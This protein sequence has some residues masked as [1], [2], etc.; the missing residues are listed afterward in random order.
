MLQKKAS[1]ENIQ[2]GKVNFNSEN[3][4]W[5]C[6]GWLERR[7]KLNLYDS[8]ETPVEISDDSNNEHYNVF[9]HF[10]FDEWEPDVMEDRRKED[11]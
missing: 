11:L 9:M 2:S 4:C 6:E 7:F 10:D 8:L 3:L 5:I 1:I